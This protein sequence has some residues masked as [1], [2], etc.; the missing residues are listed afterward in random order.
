MA[1]NEEKSFLEKHSTS[2]GILLFIGVIL[3]YSVG[4]FALC[5]LW[6]DWEIRAQAGDMTGAINT[7]FSGLAFVGVIYA[8]VLQKEE[9]RLQRKE[10][11]W[12]REELQRTAD[13]QEKAR[14]AL[15]AQVETMKLTA[16]FNAVS[17]LVAVKLGRF[18]VEH[19]TG[20]ISDLEP[21]QQLLEGEPAKIV[22]RKKWD[23]MNKKHS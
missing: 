9:L 22:G 18:Q 2:T 21:L 10:L 4:I 11:I 8:I 12:T 19:G 1:S 5:A 16:E 13:A 23:E 14:E 15:G 6:A 17:T 7:L 20:V 3:V